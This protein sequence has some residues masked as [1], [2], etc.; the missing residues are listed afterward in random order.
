MGTTT[1][2]TTK[3]TEKTK[4]NLKTNLKS[5]S[6][7]EELNE[8]FN[9]LSRFN[10]R[11]LLDGLPDNVTNQ[12]KIKEVTEKYIS[13]SIK[14]ANAKLFSGTVSNEFTNEHSVVSNCQ[15][16]NITTMISS[17]VL[18]TKQFD[19]VTSETKTFSVPNQTKAE[20]SK[21]QVVEKDPVFISYSEVSEPDDSLVN[22]NSLVNDDVQITVSEPDGQSK[23]CIQSYDDSTDASSDQLVAIHKT[24]DKGSRVKTQDKDSRVKTQDKDSRVKTTSTSYCICSYQYYKLLG[25]FAKVKSK[26]FS[27]ACPLSLS[28]GKC[29]ELD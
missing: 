28:W 23:E 25:D 18:S 1:T 12:E 2:T 7:E 11:I 5:V 29:Y 26:A 22:D 9:L 27:F 21:V 17:E 16:S 14:F 19:P 15:Q 8:W 10:D 24:Q 13:W 4:T 20:S 3:R 6:F